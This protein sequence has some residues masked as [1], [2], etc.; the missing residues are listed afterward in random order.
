MT[1]KFNKNMYAQMRS[2][3]D[4]PLSTLGTKSV[5]ITERGAPILT[6]FR[7]TPTLVTV[8]T[9][10]PTP[11]VEELTPRHK[12]PRTR[13]KQKEKVDSRPSSI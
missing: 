4:K 2:K 12:R 1:K 5:R 10:S 3:K 7:S 8:G 6:M 9:A 13:D 11:S